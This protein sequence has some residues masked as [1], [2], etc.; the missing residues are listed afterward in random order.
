MIS[1]IS[2]FINAIKIIFLLGFLV[3]IHEGGHFLVAKFFKVRVNEFSLGFGKILFQKQRKETKYCIRMIPL[4]G[5]VSMEGEEERSNKEG[6]FSELPVLKRI[7]IVVAGAIVNILFGIIVY[8][9]VVAISG[10]FYSTTVLD[11]VDGYSAKENGIVSGD[12]I[13]KIDNK[14][15]RIN[16]DITD[17]VSASNGKELEVII[18]RN[19]EEKVFKIN[20]TEVITKTIGIYLGEANKNASTEVKSIYN[21]SP[22]KNE[23]IK[24]GDNIIAVNGIEVLGDYEKTIELIKNTDTEKV[25]LTVERENKKIDFEIKPIVNKSYYIGATFGIVDNNMKDKIYYSFWTTARFSVSLID[26]VKQIFTG[27]VGMDQLMGPVGISSTVAS[28]ESISEFVYLMA[29]ISLS[30]GVTNLLPIPA[31]DGG[32]IILLIIEGI[33]KKPLKENVEITIQLI[34][35]SL[36]ILLSIIVSYNDIMRLF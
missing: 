2:F 12:K 23:G 21:N 19:G 35:F 6:S 24:T 4:G 14:K 5:F 25:H 17:I 1:V 29:L 32:K 13:L 18:E 33:R 20:P 30:L 10:N 8:F 28:T 7:A 15:V 26:N 22:A 11:I 16:S 9:S 27:N 34:G 31:L 3:L 36:I